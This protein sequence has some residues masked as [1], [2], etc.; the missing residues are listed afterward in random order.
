MAVEVS[1]SIAFDDRGRVALAG[2]DN[3]QRWAR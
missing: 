2:D 3:I 1:N